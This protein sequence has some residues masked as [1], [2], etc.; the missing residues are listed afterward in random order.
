MKFS[1]AFDPNQLEKVT[2]QYQ[3]IHKNVLNFQIGEKVFLK[4]NPDYPL[5]VIDIKDD[6]IYCK[7][8]CG[9]IDGYIPEI[10]L[11]YK[12]ACLKVNHKSEI[13]ICLN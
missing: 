4:S 9:D 8:K 13:K 7:S 5:T 1:G 10:I 12:Y 3:I 6:E 2:W 11:Q